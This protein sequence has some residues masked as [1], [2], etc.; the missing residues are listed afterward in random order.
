MRAPKITSPARVILTAMIVV[1]SL[2]MYM[3]PSF[4]ALQVNRM[5]TV[6]VKDAKTYSGIAGASLYLDG[7]LVGATDSTGK[8]TIRPANADSHQ[9]T[10]SKDGYITYQTATK[11]GLNTITA[12]LGTDRSLIWYADYESGKHDTYFNTPWAAE[13][14]DPC[15]ANHPG[16]ITQFAH[17]GAYAGYYDDTPPHSSSVCRSYY[18]IDFN[19]RQCPKIPDTRDFY[20]EL[21]VYVPST[22]IQDWFSFISIKFDEYKGIMIDSSIESKHALFIHNDIFVDKDLLQSDFGRP[23]K[24]QWPFD[25]WFKIGVEV[26]YRPSDQI[27]QVIVYQDDLEILRLQTHALDPQPRHFINLHFGLYTGGQQATFAVYNDDIT[28]YDLTAT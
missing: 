6:Y 13:T 24:A 9:L 22:T 18:N 27:S 5:P 17:S 7:V 15:G 16:N 14:A 21:W 11:V 8:I 25:K 20:V 23:I 2:S 3:G 1:M 4:A 28:L 12:Y 10:V 26:H 19:C